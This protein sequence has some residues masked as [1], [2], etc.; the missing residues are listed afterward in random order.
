MPGSCLTSG[1]SEVVGWRGEVAAL[2]WD[3]GD[4]GSFL[5]VKVSWLARVRGMQGK[6]SLSM[7]RQEA[8]RL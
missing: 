3:G 5:M 8:V 2:C 4:T 1:S 7:S 6:H